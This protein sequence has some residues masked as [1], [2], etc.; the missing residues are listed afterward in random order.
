M[1]S[2][3]NKVTRQDGTQVILRVF[4]CLACSHIYDDDDWQ[5]RCM[6]KP[7]RAGRPS[8]QTRGSRKDDLLQGHTPLAS[9]DDAPEEAVNAL[10]RY[11]KGQFKR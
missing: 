11:L 5:M 1:V 2:R 9:L 8:Q 7:V 10:K 3:Q 6:A 4:R